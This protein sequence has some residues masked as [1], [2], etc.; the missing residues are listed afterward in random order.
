MPSGVVAY[1]IILAVVLRSLV[2]PGFMLG[3]TPNSDSLTVVICT[4]HGA[5]DIQV[6]GDGLP[7]KSDE[8][9][10]EHSKCPYA[11]STIVALLPPLLIA[12]PARSAPQL[13]IAPNASYTAPSSRPELPAPAR[14]PPLA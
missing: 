10:G 8:G 13:R 1:F 11:A 4:E 14:G 9:V 7:T 2:A 12:E 3:A 6:G 5:V